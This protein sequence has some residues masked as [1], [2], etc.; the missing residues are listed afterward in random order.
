GS[1]YVIANLDG[2][3]TRYYEATMESDWRGSKGYVHGSYTWSHYYGNFDQDYSTTS[4]VN[5]NAIFIGSSNIGDGAGRQLWNFKYG[6]LRGD[7]RNSVKIYGAYYLPWNATAGPF[8]VYQSGQPY[9]L[10][11]VLPYRP[12]TGSTIDTNRY[13]ETAGSRR[14]PSQTNIDLDYTQNIRLPRGLNLQL[15]FDVF[16]LMNR[17]TGYNYETRVSVLGFTT[18]TDVPTIAIPNSI[19]PSTLASIGVASG[20]RLNAPYPNSFL[21]PRR[22]QIAARIQF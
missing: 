10:E 15:A 9:Q 12:L 13:A 14:T 3:F 8:F 4:S 22:Y 18:R 20:A 7:R 21:A 2:A 1:S 16:N 19:A 17:Q 6:N 5:D 11:S